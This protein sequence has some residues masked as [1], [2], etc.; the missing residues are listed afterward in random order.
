MGT[1]EGER[2]L[3]LKFFKEQFEVNNVVDIALEV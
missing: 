1:G 2:E 3:C